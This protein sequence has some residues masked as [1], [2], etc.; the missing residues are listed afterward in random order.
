MVMYAS[1]RICVHLCLVDLN[2]DKTI[3][4]WQGKRHCCAA[5]PSDEMSIALVTAPRGVKIRSIACVMLCIT[6]ETSVLYNH[7]RVLHALT[8]RFALI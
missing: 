3:V 4:S 1:H 6:A 5:T 7:S 2:G 8:R